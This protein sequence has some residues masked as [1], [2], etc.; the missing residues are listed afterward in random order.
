MRLLTHDEDGNIV[1]KTFEGVQPPP[2]A[3]LSHT[4][5]L[6][7]SKEVSLQDLQAGRAEDKVGYDKIRFCEQQALADGLQYFWVDTCCIDKSSSAELTEAINSMY[8]WYQQSTKCYVYLTD[9]QDSALD[10]GGKD[11][12]PPWEDMLR[13]SRWLRRGWTLQELIAPK[14][15]E[16][17]PQT[18]HD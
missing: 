4:W 1:P 5:L 2:Y 16:F 12:R 18:S 7:N 11:T 15:V 13:G 14:V 8:R 17:S 6:D 10:T 3:I 9:V